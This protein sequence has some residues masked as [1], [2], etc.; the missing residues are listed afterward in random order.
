MQKSY[1]GHPIH[2]GVQILFYV[3]HQSATETPNILKIT[4]VD[5]SIMKS[6]KQKKLPVQ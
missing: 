2:Q 4:Y 3:A 5:N 6:Q 1:G